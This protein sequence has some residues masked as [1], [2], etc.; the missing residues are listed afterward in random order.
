MGSGHA[1]HANHRSISPRAHCYLLSFLRGGPGLPV[2]EGEIEPPRERYS[3]CKSTE[4][5]ARMTITPH[6]TKTEPAALPPS[7]HWVLNTTGFSRTGRGRGRGRHWAV[8]NAGAKFKS[9]SVWAENE[10]TIYW[11]V[12]EFFNGVRTPFI[13][14]MLMNIHEKYSQSRPYLRGMLFASAPSLNCYVLESLHV[15]SDV[16]CTKSAS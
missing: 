14:I 9:T 15:H 6:W 7:F 4:P 8:R 3:K 2:E 12:L 11:S 1:L 13:L 16:L 10:M 5:E